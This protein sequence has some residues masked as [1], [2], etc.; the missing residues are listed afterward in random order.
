M[1]SRAA[2]KPISVPAADLRQSCP[3]TWATLATG[4]NSRKSRNGGQG[5]D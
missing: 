5:R 4:W 3:E 2:D 1:W